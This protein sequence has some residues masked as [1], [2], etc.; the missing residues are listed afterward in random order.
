MFKWL[1]IIFL[2]TV[3]ARFFFRARA[4]CCCY[5]YFSTF[6]ELRI[7]CKCTNVRK[8]IVKSATLSTMPFPC[9]KHF[10]SIQSLMKKGRQSNSSKTRAKKNNTQNRNMYG[11]WKK[12]T[13][14]KSAALCARKFHFSALGRCLCCCRCCCCLFFHVVHFHLLFIFSPLLNRLDLCKFSASARVTTTLDAIPLC[15]F[16]H[17]FHFSARSV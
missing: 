9:D 14:L 13:Q 3:L 8:F 15:A 5:Y 6:I 1:L 12:V 4:H 10:A 2:S 16:S 7:Q 11:V 17:L